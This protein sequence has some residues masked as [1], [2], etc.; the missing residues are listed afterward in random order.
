MTTYVMVRDATDI[1]VRAWQR[2]SW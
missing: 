1:N 2:M